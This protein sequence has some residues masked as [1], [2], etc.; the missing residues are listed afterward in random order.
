VEL[1]ERRDPI[2]L[3]VL[4]AAYAAQGDFERA[5]ATVEAGIALTSSADEARPLRER[6]LLYRGG[7]PFRLP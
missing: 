7:R 6:L 4:A 3:D 1:T 2:A 5:V